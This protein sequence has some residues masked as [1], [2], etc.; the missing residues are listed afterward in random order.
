MI[1]TDEMLEVM[2][3]EEQNIFKLGKVVG[4]WPNGTAKIQF[5]GED[6]PSDKEYAYLASAKIYNGD[7]VLVAKVA[8]TYIIL[9]VVRFK[10]IPRNYVLSNIVEDVNGNMNIDYMY[11]DPDTKILHVR[12]M[13]REW[14]SYNP[15]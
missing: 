5:D 13:N 8:K 6:G 4:F 1:T 2:Q 15:R 3:Q 14:T 12:R 9:G 7:R 11:V 10:Q